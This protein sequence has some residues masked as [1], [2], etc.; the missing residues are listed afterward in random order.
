[1]PSQTGKP[2]MFRSAEL[3]QPRRV[4][5]DDVANHNARREQLDGLQKF[6][7]E[8]SAKRRRAAK[9]WGIVTLILIAAL[10]FI[11][12]SRETSSSPFGD[13]RRGRDAREDQRAER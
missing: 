3:N 1:M 6:Y 4:T 9:R 12:S 7:L 13:M 8:E 10:I 5:P 2:I 11:L